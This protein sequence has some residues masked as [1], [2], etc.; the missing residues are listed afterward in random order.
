MSEKKKFNYKTIKNFG[1]KD[2]KK[3]FT[4]IN[5]ETIF[6]SNS[7]KELF[8]YLLQIYKQGYYNGAID[9]I[10]NIKNNR[11]TK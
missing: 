3:E 10:D 1:V 6:C 8:M 2:F 11:R 5:I 7:E 9:T 4:N